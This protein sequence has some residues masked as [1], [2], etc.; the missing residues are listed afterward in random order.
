MQ[1]RVDRINQINDTADTVMGGIESAT[2]GS[3]FAMFLQ[4]VTFRF[5][6]MHARFFMFPLA[7]A[8]AGG[9]AVAAW[10]RAKNNNYEGNTL[11]KAIIRTAAALAIGVAV[12][13]GLVASIIFGSISPII[14]SVTMLAETAWNMGS[15]VYYAG[16]AAGT[17]PRAVDEKGRNLKRHYKE[18]AKESAIGT[19]VGMLATAAVV[20]VMIFAKIPMAILG[21]VTGTIGAT[22]TAMKLMAETPE[23]REGYQTLP[24]SDDNDYDSDSDQEYDDNLE[25]GIRLKRTTTDKRS[26]TDVYL[27]QVFSTNTAASP[28]PATQPAATHAVNPNVSVVTSEPIKQVVLETD[29]ISE[30]RVYNPALREQ[31]RAKDDQEE[32]RVSARARAETE[33]VGK[34]PKQN[35][36]RFELEDDNA[37]ASRTSTYGVFAKPELKTPV[38]SQTKAEKPFNPRQ[39]A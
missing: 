26:T 19:F 1:N 4:T 11:A 33:H 21:V 35:I 6:E 17:D 12:T 22:L 39:S 20:G 16:K 37:A 28:Q 29:L 3:I 7:A 5:L 13:G 10:I 34:K 18:Q 2:I 8:L 24:T 30:S 32:S 15:I 14:F 38:A 36:M 25:N 23:K 31:Y 9:R 27:Q